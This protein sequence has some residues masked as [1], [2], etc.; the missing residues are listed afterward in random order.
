[1]SVRLFIEKDRDSSRHVYLESG[2]LIFN[3]LSP[4]LLQA[5]D[6]DKDTEGEKIW[7]YESENKIVGFISVCEPDNF[8]HHLFVLPEFSNCGYGSKLWKPA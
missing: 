7:V 3:W 4:E 6:F 8:I 1:M 5:E 2:R